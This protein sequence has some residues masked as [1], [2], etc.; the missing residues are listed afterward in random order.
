MNEAENRVIGYFVAEDDR[1]VGPP[2][3]EDDILF[4]SRQRAEAAV[5]KWSSTLDRLEVH[6]LYYQG[7]LGMTLYDT[8]D[9]LMD[10]MAAR[11]L[12]EC[13]QREPRYVHL[14]KVGPIDMTERRCIYSSR[15]MIL[16]VRETV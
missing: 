11:R 3:A 12:L 7:L 8:D 16:G 5:E 10:G 2:G 4:G 9:V 1:V 15:L 13:C 6:E 14:D